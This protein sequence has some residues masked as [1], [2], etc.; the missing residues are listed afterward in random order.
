V[1]RGSGRVFVRPQVRDTAL[2]DLIDAA[3]QRL[4]QAGMTDDR[5][6]I[7]ES[8]GVVQPRI[9]LTAPMTA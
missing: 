2:G 7:V 9:T 4:R 3:R 6:G 1:G 8:R 5:L